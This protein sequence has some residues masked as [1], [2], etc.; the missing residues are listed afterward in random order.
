MHPRGASKAAASREVGHPRMR[1]VQAQW[2]VPTGVC[3][4]AEIDRATIVKVC[5]QTSSAGH[6]QLAL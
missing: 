6:H 4:M 1:D 5:N 2:P 3:G